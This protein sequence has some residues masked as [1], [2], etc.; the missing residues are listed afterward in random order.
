MDSD[1][2]HWSG[3]FV[4]GVPIGV[5]T[6]KNKRG[7]M[8]F[9]RIVGGGQSLGVEGGEVTQLHVSALQERGGQAARRLGVSVVIPGLLLPVTRWSVRVKVRP[10]MWAV[11]IT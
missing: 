4:Y 3:V 11:F 7:D 5:P 9:A 8:M 2:T 1:T 10:A 6:Q